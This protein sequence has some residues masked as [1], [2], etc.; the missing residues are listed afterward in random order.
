MRHIYN[1]TLTKKDAQ[2]KRSVKELNKMIIINKIL[3]IISEILSIQY[4][5]LNIEEFTKY[6]MIRFMVSEYSI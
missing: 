2:N 1:V 4:P 6:S 5:D 3:R